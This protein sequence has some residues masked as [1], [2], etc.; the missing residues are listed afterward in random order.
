VHLFEREGQF[1]S[2]L[3]AKLKLPAL[4]NGL[5][6]CLIVLFLFFDNRNRFGNLVERLVLPAVET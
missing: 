2:I 4:L 5:I 6:S 1:K 3:K